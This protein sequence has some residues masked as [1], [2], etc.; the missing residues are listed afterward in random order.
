MIIASNGDRKG[1]VIR[2][3]NIEAD[4]QI[5]I[6]G[7]ARYLNPVA[8]ARRFDWLYK[9]NPHGR[10]LVWIAC[11]RTSGEY[12]GS[13]AAFPRRM[14]VG[15]KEERVWVLGDFCINADYRSLGPAVQ[16]QQAC[17]SAVECER[18]AF[19]YDFPNS[20]MTAVYSRLRISPFA[21]VLRLARPLRI[22]RHVESV[23]KSPMMAFNVAAA[24]NLLLATRNLQLL[25]NP[26]L[27]V[28]LHEGDCGEE[29]SNLARGIG[30]RNCVCVERSAE[31]LN[32]RYLGS[33]YCKYEIMT[34]RRSGDL[35]GY[36]VIAHDRKECLVADL[37]GIDDPGVIKRLVKEV[38][39][40]G[41]VRGAHT[42]SIPV[43][44][45]HPWIELFRGLGFRDRES[46]PMFV[47]S[48][49][50]DSVTKSLGNK[51]WFIMHGD[52]DS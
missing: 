18:V 26:R 50:K 33:T 40:L 46:K 48:P 47:Y 14:Y 35:Q 24:G 12:V 6:D 23:I 3:G 41:H 49:N 37:F 39:N 30:D 19:C 36:A 28:A 9:D 11:D 13:A 31:Y 7:L 22:N 20:G 17:I 38:V 32:W 29:F 5:L 27:T 25:K 21:K 42:L 44:E 1:V 45:S 10:A 8:D 16:L 15:S 43:L 51:R 34:V 2:Q 4:R 52:R